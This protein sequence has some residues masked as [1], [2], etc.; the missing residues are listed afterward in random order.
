MHLP[1]TG[2]LLLFSLCATPQARLV[3]AALE[4]ALQQ[5]KRQCPGVVSSRRERS[6]ARAL[7]LL[8]QALARV[9]LASEQAVPGG[10][11]EEEDGEEGDDGSPLEQACA[12]AGCQPEGLEGALGQLLEDAVAEALG[13]G[14]GEEGAAGEGGKRAREAAASGGSQA[15]LPANSRRV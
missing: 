3:R 1:L 2:L 15:P 12:M 5:L 7:P 13:G 9:L 6:L 8:S 11:G 4:A 14:A 10:D